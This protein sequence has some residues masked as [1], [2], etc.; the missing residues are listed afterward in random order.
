[1]SRIPFTVYDFFAYLASGAVVV[2]AVDCLYGYQWLLQ[3]NIGVVLAVFLVFAAYVAG[4]AVAH[5]S[6]LFLE[7]LFVDKLLKRP[8]RALMGEPTRCYIAWLFPGYYRALPEST[9][10]RIWM[11]ARGRGFSGSG[12][13]LFLHVYAVATQDERV[14]RRL[15]EF[16]NLYGFSRNLSFSF[17]VVAL[18]LACGACWGNRPPSHWWAVLT[19]AAGVTMLYRYLKFFR[20]YSYQ[21]FV[22]YAELPPGKGTKKQFDADNSLSER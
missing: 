21:L 5:L 14:Q 10:Q 18:L 2:G 11:Q 13:G 9:Q 20:Q 8:S 7:Q 15:D 12:E 16:R 6:S 3:P 22:T 17:L 4:H 1:M 19:A